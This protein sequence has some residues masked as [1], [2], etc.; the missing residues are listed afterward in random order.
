MLKKITDEA[1]FFC[2]KDG[3]FKYTFCM[4]PRSN[5]SNYKND[6]ASRELSK[7]I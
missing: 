5:Q 4:I 6:A 7:D 3:F 1:N 2:F